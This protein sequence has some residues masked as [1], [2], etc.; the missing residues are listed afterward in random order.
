MSDS[1]F[2]INDEIVNLQPIEGTHWV[3]YKKQNYCDSYG[4]PPLKINKP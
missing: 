2:T 4:C 3:A 1:N